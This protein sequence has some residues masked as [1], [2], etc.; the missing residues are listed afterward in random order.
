MNLCDHCIWVNKESRRCSRYEEECH[1]VPTEE[2]R[3]SA[4]W[5]WMMEETE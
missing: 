1:F 3:K 5:K 2:C 4:W